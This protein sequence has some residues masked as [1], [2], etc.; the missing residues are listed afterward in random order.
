MMI[1]RSDAESFSTTTSVVLK[2]FYNIS[3]HVYLVHWPLKLCN[4]TYSCSKLKLVLREQASFSFMQNYINVI[5]KKVGERVRQRRDGKG[6]RTRESLT[7]FSLNFSLYFF[8]RHLKAF[9]VIVMCN[10]K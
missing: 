8:S 5:E 1:L 2:L 3:S 6:V 4:Q 7:D 9:Y 10:A